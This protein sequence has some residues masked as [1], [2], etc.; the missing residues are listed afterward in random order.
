MYEVAW[1][2]SAGE[3]GSLS[4]AFRPYPVTLPFEEYRLFLPVPFMDNHKWFHPPPQDFP[5][6]LR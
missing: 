3:V 1:P 2:L 5:L 6:L 4:P